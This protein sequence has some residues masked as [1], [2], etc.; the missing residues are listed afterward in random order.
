[1]VSIPKHRAHLVARSST[2]QHDI[3][4]GDMF[5]PVMKNAIIRFVLSLVCIPWLDSSTH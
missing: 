3:N 1:M 5:S 2:Q 4:Y